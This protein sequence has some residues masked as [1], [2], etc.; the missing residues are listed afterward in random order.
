MEHRFGIGMTASGELITKKNVFA[1]LVMGSLWDV[2]CYGQDGKLKWES[3]GNRNVMTNQGL[4]HVLN[5]LFHGSAQIETWYVV[6]FENDYDPQASDTYAS[7]GF[8]ESTAYSETDRV[9]FNGA[10]VLGQSVT[11]AANK[12]TFNV[13]DTKYFFG[14]AL[15]GGGLSPAVKGDTEGGGTLLCAAKFASS[16]PCENGDT[17]KITATVSAQNVT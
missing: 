16:K 2:E 1:A 12:A 15:V 8:E 17:F 7:P 10:E 4:D 13:T 3:R 5:I 9:V 11:N 6:P 14:A